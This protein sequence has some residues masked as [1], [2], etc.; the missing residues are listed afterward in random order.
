MWINHF[1]DLFNMEAGQFDDAPDQAAVQQS[2]INQ[3]QHQHRDLQAAQDQ[4]TPYLQRQRRQ[5]I[6]DL[7]RPSSDVEESDDDLVDDM[8][9]DVDDDDEDDDDDYEDDM[10]GY[11]AVED[12]DWEL[13]R[14]DFT[15]HFNRSRQL[16]NA[17]HA[18]SSTACASAST[19]A[20]ASASKST[21]GQAAV[22]ATP[23]PA[24]NRRR[25]PPLV[26]ASGGAAATAAS[27]TQTRT[28][29]QM[30]SLSKFASRIRVDDMY[31]PSSAIG[32]GVNSTV[33]RKALGGR[34]AVRIK[35]KADRATVEGV[36]DPRT[37]LILYKMVNRGL[38]ECVNGCVS[39]GKEANV[40]HATTAVTGSSNASGSSAVDSE[41]GSLALKIYKTSILVFKDR[42]RYVSGEFRFRHG[43]AK[44]NP[45]KMVRLWAEKEARN[46]KRMVSAGLRAPVPVELRDHVLVMQFLGDS[47]GWA[48]PRL[49]DADE[50]I[51]SDRAEWSRLYREL[52]ASVRIMY[53]QCRLVHADLS[54]YNILYHQHHLWIIDV[55]QSVEHDHPRAYD[56]LRADLAHVDD[57]F[58]KRGVNTLGLRATFEFV[59]S[60]PKSHAFA[61]KGGRAGL[62][63]QEADFQ[64][65]HRPNPNEEHDKQL[66]SDGDPGSCTRSAMGGASTAT[67]VVVSKDKVIGG[68]AWYTGLSQTTTDTWGAPTGDESESSL[69]DTLEHL[70]H[71][72]STQPDSS[73]HTS[74]IPTTSSHRSANS[75]NDDQVFKATY[76]PF[77]L[78][79]LQDPEREIEL[80][81]TSQ[82]TTTQD[83]THPPLSTL[84]PSKSAQNHDDNDDNDDSHSD[85]YTSSDTC[86][87]SDDDQPTSSQHPKDARITKEQAKALK[88]EAKKQ[89]KQA[90]REKRKTKMPK[91]EKKRRM[92]KNHK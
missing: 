19:S 16:A 55:S 6:S 40:Y 53:H 5:E 42:D 73:S 67:P 11:G 78:H 58:A 76:I 39:T 22:T 90:N 61:R 75:H 20:S 18:S 2:T 49:K 30:E 71:Q 24:M 54:E 3:N 52:I 92:K 70:M 82:P 81:A 38:L 14:G 60:A 57:F 13:A 8:Q 72:L 36:L 10:T 66:K 9:Q 63:K 85:H 44:H 4:D 27:T 21:R 31:D 84:L 69:M 46:L 50:I 79:E 43:Y 29:S 26:A 47:Q 37:I 25:R 74:A 35:D 7:L 33:P 86:D 87:V 15:K 62:E 28:A 68:G 45:R 88:K 59:V 34:D 32:G 51:G 80:Q 65:D 64:N 89:T 48:S 1:L 17:I 91:A 83:R 41:K 77:S 56:F 12:A 23:L